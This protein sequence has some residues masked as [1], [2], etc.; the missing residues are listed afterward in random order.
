VR[1]QEHVRRI[2]SMAAGHWGPVRARIPTVPRDAALYLWLVLSFAVLVTAHVTLAFGLA[3]RRPR[4]R[5]LVS[6]VVPP[7][8]PYWGYTSGLRLR[9]LVWAAGLGAYLGAL[10]TA[11]ASGT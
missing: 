11:Y 7:L 5:G 3:L 10:L 8:A 6:L 9:T 2:R 4:W 1:G